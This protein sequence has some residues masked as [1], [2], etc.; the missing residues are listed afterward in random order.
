[1]QFAFAIYVCI[2][3]IG[4]KLQ[5]RKLYVLLRFTVHHNRVGI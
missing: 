1:M 4:L 3:M 5:C 2:I